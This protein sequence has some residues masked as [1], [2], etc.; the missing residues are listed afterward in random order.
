MPDWNEEYFGLLGLFVK[1]RMS[2]VPGFW[3]TLALWLAP[4]AMLKSAHADDHAEQHGRDLTVPT[5]LRICV[6]CVSQVGNKKKPILALLQN[7]PIYRELLQLYPHA[8]L[9]VEK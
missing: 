3:E 4:L 1:R 8:E 5:P 2:N 6:D 7:T 9:V